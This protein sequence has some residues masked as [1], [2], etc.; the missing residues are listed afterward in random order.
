MHN[1]VTISLEE[2]KELLLKNNKLN[3]T[4]KIVL[5]RIKE[6]MTMIFGLRL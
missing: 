6:Y 2:Y 1:K 3:E 4:Q 5:E